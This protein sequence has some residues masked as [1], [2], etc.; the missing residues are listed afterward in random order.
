[1]TKRQIK[2]D[3]LLAFSCL[4]EASSASTAAAA[5]SCLET[6]VGAV[7]RLTAADALSWALVGRNR[8]HSRQAGPKRLGLL[9]GLDC[10]RT[11]N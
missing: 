11:V 6:A 10:G 2:T 1:M 4:S 5:R 3:S 7:R 9:A 8:N